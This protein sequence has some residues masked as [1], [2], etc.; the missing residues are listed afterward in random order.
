MIG[1]DVDCPGFGPG[2]LGTGTGPDR[3]HRSECPGQI[4]VGPDLYQGLRTGPQGRTGSEPGP[5]LFSY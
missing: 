4:K 5:D 1:L 3:T 2:P